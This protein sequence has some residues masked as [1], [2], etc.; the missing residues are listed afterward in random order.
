MLE[1]SQSD[2]EEVAALLD[3]FET[4][5]A[6]EKLKNWIGSPLEQGMHERIKNALIAL[7]DEFDEDASIK[8]LIEE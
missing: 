1:L 2:L 4:D 7:E 3:D 5:Q 8:L 6:I